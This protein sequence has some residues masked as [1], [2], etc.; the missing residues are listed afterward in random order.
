MASLS[1]TVTFEACDPGWK[2]SHRGMKITD[3]APCFEGRKL[4]HYAELGPLQ[5]KSLTQS[6]D[7]LG[8][9]TNAWHADQRKESVSVTHESITS[10]IHISTCRRTYVVLDP[11]S[12]LVPVAPHRDVCCHRWAGQ[13]LHYKD[14]HLPAQTKPG[15]GATQNSLAAGKSCGSAPVQQPLPLWYLVL[16]TMTIPKL[17]P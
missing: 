15:L 1:K 7:R 3:N 9:E 10:R 4:L 6:Y 11:R 17:G 13:G 12:S 14:N 5:W 2:C 8:C 16:T